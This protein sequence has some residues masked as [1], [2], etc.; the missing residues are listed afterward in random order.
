L[1]VTNCHRWWTPGP[2]TLW[3]LRKG[4]PMAKKSGCWDGMLGF[5]RCY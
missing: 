4:M 5:P 3:T 1:P 2:R